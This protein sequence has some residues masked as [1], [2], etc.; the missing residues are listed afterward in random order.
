MRDWE[1]YLNR[2]IACECHRTHRCGIDRIVIGEGALLELPAMIRE[3]GY[4][5]ICMV[6]D[7]N[8]YAAA[9][10]QAEALLA[11]SGILCTKAVFPE[12]E[13]IPDE[14]ALGVLLAGLPDGCDLM[15]CVGSGTLGDL[16]KFVSHKLHIDYFM[17]ATAPSMDGY[18]SNVAP[19]IVKDT[20]TTYEVGRPKAIIGDVNILARAPMEMI[21]AGI[22]DMLGKYVC[23]ADW[24]VAHIVT[25]EYACGFV[26]NM[27]RECVDVVKQAMDGANRREKGAIAAVMEGLVLSGIT[28]SYVGNSRPASGSEHHL[29]HFWEMMLLQQGKPDALHGLKV[30]VGTVIS[31]KLYELLKNNKEAFLKPGDRVLSQEKWEGE[32]R[33]VYGPAAPEVIRLEREMR[34]NALEQ[35]EERRKAV[36]AHWDEIMRVAKSLPSAEEMADILNG[37]GAPYLPCQ[38]GVDEQMARDGIIYAK[39][40]RNRYGL[41]QLLFDG[42]IA[43]GMAGDAMGF[44]KQL[45]KERQT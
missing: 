20:K 18:A 41:L 14:H 45:N 27:M 37:I 35:V 3:G 36:A 5:N 40:L 43:Q 1:K 4:K 30:A 6:A 29:S 10:K 34:K 28:M 15:V 13:L 26:E 38:I 23:L 16:C 31:L 11:G 25:G 39:E 9:G 32:I 44:L 24:R 42:G 8:T 22:G 12:A 7:A 21:R 2:D 19:L 33:R 17:V